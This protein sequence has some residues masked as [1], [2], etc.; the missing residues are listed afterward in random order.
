[1][2][3]FVMVALAY[4]AGA[5]V[6]LRNGWRGSEQPG[7]RGADDWS[8]VQ[9]SLAAGVSILLAVLTFGS[10]DL[11][12]GQRLDY[13]QVQAHGLAYRVFFLE[14]DLAGMRTVMR[15]VRRSLQLPYGEGK[16]EL[17]RICDRRNLAKHGMLAPLMTPSYVGMFRTATVTETKIRLVEVAVLLRH[18][19]FDHD[20]FPESLD[21]LVPEYAQRLPADPLTD[22]K[23]QFEVLAKSV[24]L[25]SL[26][27]AGENEEQVELVLTSPSAK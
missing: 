12:V 6:I 4:S 25:Y 26:G 2:A 20:R 14:R 15:E 8:R 27:D 19:E 23:F 11:A 7:S 18:Y 3:F 10:L 16:V 22:G 9:L 13:Q 1:M 17:E 21:A 5:F 24:R